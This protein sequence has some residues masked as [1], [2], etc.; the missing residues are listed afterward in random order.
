MMVGSLTT[1]HVLCGTAVGVPALAAVPRRPACTAGRPAGD[2]S[3]GWPER[4]KVKQGDL[5]PPAPR[6]RHRLTPPY[7]SG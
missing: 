5:L 6:A 1:P 2:D 4:P 3:A 7:L